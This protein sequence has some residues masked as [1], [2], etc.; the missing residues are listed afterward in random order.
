MDG[1]GQDKVPCGAQPSIAV[2]ASDPPLFPTLEFPLYLLQ[3]RET[4]LHSACYNPDAPQVVDLMI[5]RGNDVNA[6]AAVRIP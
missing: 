4:P 2:T 6:R 1:F 3:E 5:K